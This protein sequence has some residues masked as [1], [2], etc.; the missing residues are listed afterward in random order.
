MTP[1]EKFEFFIIPMR[2]RFVIPQALQETE[3]LADLAE[4]LS[5]YTT[6]QLGTA[7]RWFRDNRTQR[8]FPTIA[9]CRTACERFS[10]AP[11]LPSGPRFPSSA[12][13]RSDAIRQEIRERD[14]A[15]LCRTWPVARQAHR[16]G[17]L[18]T[19]LEFAEDNLREPSADE[20]AA[21]KAKAERTDWNLHREPRPAAYDMLC[22]LRAVMKARAAG[23]LWGL[24]E[25]RSAGETISGR[26][27][28]Q[29]V[30]EWSF[31]TEA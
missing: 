4:A 8:G 30:A 12:E 25:P 29:A 24:E 14:G 3:F 23:R 16:E 17:W 6:Y 28:V 13:V 22:K 31:N 5:G 19:L 1:D 20:L 21:L 10:A 2:K 26:H 15:A 27:G 11:S 9:E 18:T 7:A